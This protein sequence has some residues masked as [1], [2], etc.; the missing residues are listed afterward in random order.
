MVQRDD[1]FRAAVGSRDIIGQAKG[2]LMERFHIDA[3]QAFELLKRLSQESN[4]PLIRVA[5][6]VVSGRS[7]EPHNGPE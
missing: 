5:G 1:Q 4:T 3:A 7:Y 2:M 6:Q